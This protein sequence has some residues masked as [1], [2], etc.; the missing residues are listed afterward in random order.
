METNRCPICGKTAKVI[1][2]GAFQVTCSECGQFTLA[3]TLFSDGEL[4]LGDSEKER[5]A[6]IL[7]ERH[8]RGSKELFIANAFPSVEHLQPGRTYVT[9]KQLLSEYPRSAIEILDRALENIA[10]RVGHPASQF[11]YETSWDGIMFSRG[12]GDTM[13]QQL[14]SCGYLAHRPG[15]SHHYLMTRAGWDRAEK[16]KFPG[17]DSLQGF[18]AMSFDESRTEC[19]ENGIKPG[20]EDGTDFTCR[21]IDRKE[22]NNRI[23]DEMIAEI[24]RSRFLVA[25][26]TGQRPNVYFEAGFA[27]GLGIPVIWCVQE[28]DKENFHFDTRQYSRLVYEDPAD[29]KVKLQN[30]IR[31]TIY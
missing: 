19:Y 6:C 31:A 26:A 22:H 27:L 4:A 14:L 2:H 1:E 3:I 17:R 23:D 5:L 12:R 25:D 13:I 30:R 15:A 28:S 7:A 21:R 18:V 8:L 11:V 24:R 20:I 16:L 29:L 10:L 9:I